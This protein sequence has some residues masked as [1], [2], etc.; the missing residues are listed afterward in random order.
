MATTHLA[1]L[2]C[3]YCLCLLAMRRGVLPAFDDRRRS[4]AW[5]IMSPM[6]SLVW[7]RCGVEARLAE[8]VRLREEGQ[9]EAARAMLLE[10]V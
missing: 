10:L 3:W 7:G 9:L 6:P 1:L 2:T 5:R 4:F 8:A